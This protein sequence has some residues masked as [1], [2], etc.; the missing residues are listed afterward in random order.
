MINNKNCAEGSKSISLVDQYYAMLESENIKKMQIIKDDSY[1]NWLESFLN[2]NETATTFSK[3][4]YSGDLTPLDISN[5]EKLDLLYAIIE[6][7]AN[8]NYIASTAMN[9][10]LG[11][12]VS[13]RGFFFKIIKSHLDKDEIFCSLAPNISLLSSKNIIDFDKIMNDVGIVYDTDLKKSLEEL[14]NYIKYLKATGVPSE[15]IRLTIERN[16]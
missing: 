6:R 16:L 7:Y 11:Y 2:V 3:V 9:E 5:L 10:G 1:I 12:F 14:A 15:S 4:T 8:H 13:F